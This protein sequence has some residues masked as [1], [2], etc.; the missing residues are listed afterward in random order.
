MK[1]IKLYS[2]IIT[3]IGVFDSGF[4]GLQTLKYLKSQFPHENFL[5]LADN[6]NVPYG[7]KDED[8]IRDLTVKNITWLLGQ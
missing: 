4:G 1:K 2:L 5:F 8:T 7:D 3:M 6:K